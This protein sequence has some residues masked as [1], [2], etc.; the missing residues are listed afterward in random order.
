MRNASE[1][2]RSDTTTA[3]FKVPA[4]LLRDFREVARS[5]ER[6]FSQEL[7]QIMA[8]HIERE[9]ERAAA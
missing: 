5:H 9:R 8:E 4:R 6:T 2:K 7:R 1:A 3:T